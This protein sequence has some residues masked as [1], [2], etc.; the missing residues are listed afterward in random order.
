MKTINLLPKFRQ[1]EL[2]YESLFGSLWI[3]F[4]LSAASFMVVFVFQFAAKFYLEAKAKNITQEISSLQTQVSAQQDSAIKTQVQDANN[5]ILDFKNLAAAA[6][7]WSK[8]LIAFAPLP[9]PGI[10]INSFVIDPMSKSISIAG[11]SPTRELVIQLYNNILADNKEFYNID[12]PLDNVSKPTDV[13]FH[14]IFYMRDQ[15]NQ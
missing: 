6:P 13:D 11:F 9:P 3:V 15:L 12:Y 14:F 5:T 10:Q 2:R 8:V 4:C 1:Q 7:K